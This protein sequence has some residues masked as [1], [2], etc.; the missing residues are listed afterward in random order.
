M[1]RNCRSKSKREESGISNVAIECD[2]IRRNTIR[3]RRLSS[4]ILT[5]ISRMFGESIGLDTRVV[6]A[7]ND[8]S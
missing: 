6:Q 3:R 4:F 2:D 5:L 7:V 1:F 8:G